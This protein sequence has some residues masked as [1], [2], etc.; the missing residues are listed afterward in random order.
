MISDEHRQCAIRKPHGGF[1]HK[2]TF[3]LMIKNDQLWGGW[4]RGIFNIQADGTF[5]G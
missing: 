2:K 3:S 5:F 4:R 1:R